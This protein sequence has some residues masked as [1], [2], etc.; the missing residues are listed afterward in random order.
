MSNTNGKKKKPGVSPDAAKILEQYR[1]AAGKTPHGGAAPGGTASTDGTGN[2][3][4]RPTAP[5][6][7]A[8][9]QRSGTR[10]K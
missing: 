1:N 10:G 6:A 5:P 8:V 7:P 2:A 9:K 3:A 4:P